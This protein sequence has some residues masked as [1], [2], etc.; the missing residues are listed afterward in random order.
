MFRSDKKKICATCGKLDH[1]FNTDE[2]G[3]IICSSCLRGE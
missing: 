3:E 2:D 1:Y